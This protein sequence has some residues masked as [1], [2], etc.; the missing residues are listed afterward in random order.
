MLF[1]PSNVSPDEITGTGCVDAS[2][3]MQVS[4]QVNGDSAMTAYK[5]DIYLNDAAST[6][7]LSTGK[8]ELD[9]PFWGVDFRGDTKYYR[10]EITAAE[11]AAA[12]IVNGN[13]YKLLI[14]QWWGEKS[15]QQSTASVFVTR[16][17]PSVAINT[18]PN[19]VTTRSQT[20]TAAYTQA[21]GDSLKWVRWEIAENANR[22]QP[23]VD[24]GKITGTGELKAEYDGFFTGTTYAIRCSIETANGI[25]ADSGWVTFTVTYQVTEP[26]GQVRACQ[27][28]SESAV[29][30]NWD[31]MEIA[32]GYSVLRRKDGENVLRKIADVDGS[33]GQLRDYSAV[34]GSRYVYYI[35]PIGEQAYLTEPMVSDVVSVQ[36]WFWSI[37]EA[38]E[39][40]KNRFSVIKDYVFRMGS[41]GVQEG[42]FSNNNNPQ[43]LKNF[44]PYPTRMGDSA[45]YLTGSVSGFIGQLTP[46][47][48]MYSDTVGQAEKL[49]SLSCSRNALFLLDPKGHFL[50]IHTSSPTALAVNH[51]NAVMPQTMT[52][53]W[54]ELGSTE[55]VSLYSAPGGDFYPSDAVI[56]TKFRVDMNTGSLV[57]EV[58]DGYRNGSIMSMNA[59]RKLVQTADGAFTPAEMALDAETME[60][61]AAIT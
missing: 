9:T 25:T 2:G 46:A 36:F 4:W 29:Y 47:G 10:A 26:Q 14:T 3:D 16:A 31:R 19:P 35:F 58:P 27:I 38:A 40:A 30:I 60:V 41:G 37:I 7:K 28:R 53:N 11:I 55:N 21:Q 49:M 48:D 56:G 23:F 43:F 33:T 17:A 24:T 6:P 34:S 44:T 39:T 59:G 1:Q 57:W 52:I 61:S 54:T 8:I 20:F 15:V 51:K 42:Q 32:Q 18:I 12:G 5:I 50:R 45:N 22:E 13:E